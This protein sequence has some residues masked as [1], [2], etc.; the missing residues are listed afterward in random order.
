MFTTEEINLLLELLTI[1]IS[2][3]S[4]EEKNKGK[5]GS[6]EIIKRKLRSVLR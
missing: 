3:L 5:I 2:K 1:E 6:Y 4:L